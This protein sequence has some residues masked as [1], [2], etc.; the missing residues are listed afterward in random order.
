MWISVLLSYFPQLY[1][2]KWKPC[3]RPTPLC[4]PRVLEGDGSCIQFSSHHD[5][6][7][8]V[9]HQMSVVHCV[10]H[11]RSKAKWFMRHCR[12]ILLIL[13]LFLHRRREVMASWSFICAT[14]MPVLPDCVFIIYEMT[15]GKCREGDIRSLLF[16]AHSDRGAE[17][18][19]YSNP[20]YSR[21]SYV[22]GKVYSRLVVGK[23]NVR[24][25]G[26]ELFVKGHTRCY[27]IQDRE[28]FCLHYKDHHF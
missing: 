28:Q 13:R 15:A 24:L 17:G 1:F 7:Q 2:W 21:L 27:A 9:K 11:R 4:L 25:V 23:W 19:T 20:L 26:E 10:A 3:H 8:V 14:E 22:H 6:Q 5:R 12:K 16:S 18:P